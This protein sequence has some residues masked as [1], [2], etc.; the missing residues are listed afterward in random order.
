MISSNLKGTAQ[1]TFYIDIDGNQVGIRSNA[2]ILELSNNGGPWYIPGQVPWYKEIFIVDLTIQTTGVI[3][4]SNTPFLESEF[5][6]RN[7][8]KLIND[9]TWDYTIS[10]NIITINNPTTSLDIGDAIEVKYQA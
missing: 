8:L 3:T 10:T 4:L 6:Y 9:V 2:G 7:G 1:S 5:V